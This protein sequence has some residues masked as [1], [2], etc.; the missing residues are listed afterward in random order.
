MLG[1]ATSSEYS[2]PTQ[3]NYKIEFLQK[4]NKFN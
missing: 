1:V 3:I 4:E 2:H